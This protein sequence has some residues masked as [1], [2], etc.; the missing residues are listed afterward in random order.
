MSFI[1]IGNAVYQQFRI[2][3][4]DFIIVK[5][6]R[7]NSALNAFRNMLIQMSEWHDISWMQ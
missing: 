7:S 2:T 5:P 6:K 1:F 3:L 4:L